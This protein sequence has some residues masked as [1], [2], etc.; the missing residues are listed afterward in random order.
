MDDDEQERFDA[1]L[2]KWQE[3]LRPLSEGIDEMEDIR[4]EDLAMYI[5]PVTE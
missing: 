3:R 4:S 1:A 2:V 5:G